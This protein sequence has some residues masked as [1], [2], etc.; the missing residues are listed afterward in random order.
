MVE[1]YVHICKFLKSNTT[2]SNTQPIIM[3][4]KEEKSMRTSENRKKRKPESKAKFNG[5]SNSC[6]H[7]RRT[8]KKGRQV[9][10]NIKEKTQ[11][12]LYKIN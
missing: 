11:R 9:F 8:L 7:R 6:E 5:E 1:S 3:K 2:Y 4:E 10:E 12:I